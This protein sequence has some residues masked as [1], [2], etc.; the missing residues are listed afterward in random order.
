MCSV[1]TLLS[2]SDRQEMGSLGRRI[3][4][5]GGRRTLCIPLQR[6]LISSKDQLFIILDSSCGFMSNWNAIVL[7]SFHIVVA[8][9]LGSICC[10]HFSFLNPNNCFSTDNFHRGYY[11]SGVLRRLQ[12]TGPFTCFR[13]CLL[14]RSCHSVDYQSDDGL[15]ELLYLLAE[16]KNYTIP[17][18]GQLHIEKLQMY[19]MSSVVSVLFN[20][21]QLI[22]QA[23]EGLPRSTCFIH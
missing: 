2:N 10:P 21:S 12:N 11:S 4:L 13:E 7:H 9:M 22:K 16:K 20:S 18:D 19:S 3:P 5:L 8:F 17:P 6:S 1:S 14:R 15:C 23:Q